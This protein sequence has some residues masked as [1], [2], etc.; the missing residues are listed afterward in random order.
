[1]NPRVARAFELYL[2]CRSLNFVHFEVAK[3]RGKKVEHKFVPFVNG[4]S[5]LPEPGGALDQPVWTM[6]MFEVFRAGENV[7]SQ[8][9]NLK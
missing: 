7:G 9:K 5:T 6:A 4:W 8:E 3:E 2:Q 1:M